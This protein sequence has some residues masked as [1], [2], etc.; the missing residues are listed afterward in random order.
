MAAQYCIF[1][2]LRATF[3]CSFSLLGIVIQRQRAGWLKNY[4]ILSFLKPELQK[5]PPPRKRLLHESVF[6]FLLLILNIKSK[7]SQLAARIFPSPEFWRNHTL[8][9]WFMKWVLSAKL[10]SRCGVN[11][12]IGG[13]GEVRVHWKLHGNRPRREYILINRYCP[14]S[15]LFRQFFYS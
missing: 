8:I 1:I 14:F 12:H 3:S 6:F 10:T 15:L 11:C 7:S 13:G 4:I 9:W 5:T 2:R